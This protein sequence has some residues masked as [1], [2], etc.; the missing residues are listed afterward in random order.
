MIAHEGQDSA[1]ARAIGR[2]IKGKLSLAIYAA[3]IGLAFVLPAISLALYVVVA[4]IW[5]IPDQRVERVVR[6]P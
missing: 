6:E 3:A 5:F 2:D 4:A 1:L